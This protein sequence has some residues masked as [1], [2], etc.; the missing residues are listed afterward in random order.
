MPFCTPAQ[1][2]HI[3]DFVIQQSASTQNLRHLGK[4]VH[5]HVVSMN[6]Q[7]A[8][9]DYSIGFA[10]KGAKP[11]N[12]LYISTAHGDS[13]LWILHEYLVLEK[14][15]SPAAAL[16]LELKHV[17]GGR[18]QEYLIGRRTYFDRLIAAA[19]T[20]LFKEEDPAPLRQVRLSLDNKY[21][22]ALTREG[23][24]SGGPGVT[25]LPSSDTPKDKP[26][27]PV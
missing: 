20:G 19:G 23:S 17:D 26:K 4:D 7:P 14:G 6:L 13:D 22:A 25:P 9:D 18:M 27:Q 15:M 24:A 5:Y 8:F 21:K 1:F 10:V 11:V 16:D 3:N 2:K 12:A